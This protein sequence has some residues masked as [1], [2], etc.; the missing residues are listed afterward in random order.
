MLASAIQSEFV[1]ST[2]DFEACP[3]DGGPDPAA[4]KA[5]RAAVPLQLRLNAQVNVAVDRRA[6]GHVV[7]PG[8]EQRDRNR[9]DRTG[10]GRLVSGPS[11]GWYPQSDLA[12]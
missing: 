1:R 6:D 9:G 4:G 2:G 8:L 5:L 7:P 12:S 10:G 11:G 3:P